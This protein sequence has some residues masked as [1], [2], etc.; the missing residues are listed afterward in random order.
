M[1]SDLLAR[2]PCDQMCFHAGEQVVSAGGKVEVVPFGSSGRV[3]R[4][5]EAWE[6]GVV[7]SDFW[8]I[9]VLHQVA[10]EAAVS[11]LVSA[12]FRQACPLLAS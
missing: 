2:C 3:A 8:V 10:L 4:L 5:Q 6:V 1:T 7:S 11:A 9:A 12:R